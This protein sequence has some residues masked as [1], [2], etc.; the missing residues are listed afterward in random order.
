MSYPAA[1]AVLEKAV[2]TLLLAGRARPLVASSHLCVI[3]LDYVCFS[4]Y[5]DV[6]I[7]LCVLKMHCFYEKKRV[8]FLFTTSALLHPSLQNDP[9]LTFNWIM[10]VQVGKATEASHTQIRKVKRVRP[11]RSRCHLPPLL[12]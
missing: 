5:N 11:V 8:Q 4:Y 3:Q 12:R 1:A 7:G 6:S 10:S 9:L 2:Q